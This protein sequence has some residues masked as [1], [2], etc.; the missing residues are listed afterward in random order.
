MASTDFPRLPVESAKFHEEKKSNKY[1]LKSSVIVQT[2]NARAGRR[3]KCSV[4]VAFSR[5]WL[6]IISKSVRQSQCNWAE[7]RAQVSCCVWSMWKGWG[8]PRERDQPQTSPGRPFS[9]RA[10]RCPMGIWN[11]GQSEQQPTCLKVNDHSY[12]RTCFCKHLYACLRVGSIWPQSGLEL[13]NRSLL[14]WIH[15][16]YRILIETVTMRKWRQRERCCQA[17][18]LRARGRAYARALRLANVTLTENRGR[19]KTEII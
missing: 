16:V 11:T 4:Y 13:W 7:T 15:T 3:K 14:D 1:L 10:E 18:L 2:I 12:I 6:M 5:T 19:D 9:V 8:W 17:S